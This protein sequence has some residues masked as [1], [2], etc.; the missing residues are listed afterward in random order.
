MRNNIK[1][2]IGFLTVLATPFVVGEVSGNEAQ[3][4]QGLGTKM[5]VVWY[6]I[7]TA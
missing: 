7:T 6:Y 2:G 5:G 1:I 3:A 4:A